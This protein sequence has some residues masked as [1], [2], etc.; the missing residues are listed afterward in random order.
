M[1]DDW[2]KVSVEAWSAPSWKEAA[3]QYRDARA[4]RPLIVEIEPAHLRLLRRLLSD[5]ISLERAS[6]QISRAAREYSHAPEATYKAVA[7]ELRTNGISQLGESS[8][9]RRLCDLS[10]AQIKALMASL[11]AGRDQY[12]KINDELLKALARIYNEKVFGDGKS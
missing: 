12:P 11:Q 8:C 3:A 9:R 5:E 6:A 7:Y 4:G 2:K 1:M 10:G